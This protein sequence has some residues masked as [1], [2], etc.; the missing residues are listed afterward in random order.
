MSVTNTFEK[1][2]YKNPIFQG[3][4]SQV[5]FDIDTRGQVFYIAL[6]PVAICIPIGIIELLYLFYNIGRHFERLKSCRA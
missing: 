4:I 2:E 5:L 1:A 3:L 6:G